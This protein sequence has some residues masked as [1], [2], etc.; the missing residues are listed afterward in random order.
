MLPIKA[1]EDFWGFDILSN[2]YKM[3]ISIY[4]LM[5]SYLLVAVGCA[6]TSGKLSTPTASS[7]KLRQFSFSQLDS[8][9]TL[10]QRPVAVFLHAEW[11]KY[12]KNMEQTTFQNE[13]VIHLLNEKY[14]FISFD[15]EQK[16]K[17][18]FNK[19]RFDYIPNG[20]NSGTHQL[21][22][23]LGTVDGILAYPALVIL[24]PKYEII[25]QY[26]GFLEDQGLTAIL[27]KGSDE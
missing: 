27:T 6:S 22:A 10:E 9:M 26:N 5:G 11:C 20:R 14:Y 24:N 1:F 19:H 8:L 7:L 13:S 4:L 2:R 18:V 17:V 23:A 3:R 16:E 25:F 21:A 15:G 12:C